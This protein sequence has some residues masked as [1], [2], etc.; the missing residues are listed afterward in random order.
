ME[1][2]LRVFKFMFEVIGLIKK[3]TVLLRPLVI[4]I[5]VGGIASIALSIA[6]YFVTNGTIAWIVLAAGLVL[7]YF[8]DY[9]NN[10]LTVSLVHEVLT[11]GKASFGNALS[12]SGRSAP[13]IIVFASISAFF[14]LLASYAEERDD[15]VGKIITQVLYMIWT[16]T[17]YLVMPTMVIEETGFFKAFSRSKEV[18]KKDPTQVGIGVV[19]IGLMNWV[20]GI[21]CIAL[22]Y[23]ALNVLGRINP[24]LGAFSFYFIVNSYWGISGYIKITYF[25]CFY[26]WAKE[27]ETKKSSDI[28]LAPAPLSAV[29]AN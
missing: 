7:L 2:Y 1:K 18:M 21:A 23:G 10:A 17:T 11:T 16:T 3:N 26:M 28:S 19:G 12:K 25:T 5:V 9:F 20:L 27:C 22:A 29:L 14:D 15:I 24:F 6:L 13:G 4:N 8:I